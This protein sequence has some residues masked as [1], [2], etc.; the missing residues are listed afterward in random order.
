M[1]IFSEKTRESGTPT[2]PAAATDG[3]NQFVSNLF[4]TQLHNLYS[5]VAPES[6]EN[7][8][9]FIRQWDQSSLPSTNYHLPAGAAPPSVGI[10]NN[11]AAVN[12]IGDIGNYRRDEISER[13]GKHNAL[14]KWHKSTN[15]QVN[16]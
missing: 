16:Y 12:H 15:I 11:N 7:S 1:N 14:R 13:Q 4:N 10:N 3:N 2:P 9:E 8:S 6:D 5:F